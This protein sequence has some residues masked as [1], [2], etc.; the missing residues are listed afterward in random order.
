MR[1]GRS[2]GRTGQAR[3][4]RGRATPHRCAPPSHAPPGAGCCGAPT[5]TARCVCWGSGPAHLEARTC[6][7]RSVSRRTR[8]ASSTQ[9]LV[10]AAPT[11]QVYRY[12]AH[13]MPA[14]PAA[15]VHSEQLWCTVRRRGQH[16]LR[17]PARASLAATLATW[18]V[19]VV[20]T[21]PTAFMRRT[22]TPRCIIL[23]RCAA[24]HARG[25]A[26]RQGP[27]LAPCPKAP[28]TTTEAEWEASSLSGPLLTC[29]AGRPVRSA[30]A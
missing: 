20:C 25:H 9:K 3:A 2:R 19:G 4:V 28:I 5:R 15:S 26:S 1:S 29:F 27:C 17:S 18:A 24:T 13:G 16:S 11:D 8:Y 6:A 10:R 22:A 23:V 7:G 30:G 12:P 14:W 21:T